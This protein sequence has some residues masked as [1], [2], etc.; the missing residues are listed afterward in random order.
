M[1]DKGWKA[2][3][4]AHAADVGT[5]RIPVTGERDGADFENAVFCFQL[6]T[7]KM[8]PTWLFD[9]LDGIVGNATPKRKIGVLVLRRP[10]QPR[11]KS[12]VVLRWDDWCDLHGGTE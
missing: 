11:R 7:R 1:S 3:E 9:W 10:N 4:R 2:S 6:K 5:K 8:L 12:L